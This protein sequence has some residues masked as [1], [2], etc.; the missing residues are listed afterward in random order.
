MDKLIEIAKAN[1]GKR[2]KKELNEWTKDHVYINH[3]TDDQLHA[4]IEQVCAPLVELIKN[5]ALVE[6]FMGI[7]GKAKETLA[8]YNAI[9]GDK[10]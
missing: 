1:G 6:S 4:T 5:Q 10:K 3:L 8:A 2:W 9:M 7:E